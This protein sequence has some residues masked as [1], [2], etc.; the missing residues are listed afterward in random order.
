MDLDA[1]ENVC[2]FSNVRDICPSFRATLVDRSLRSGLPEVNAGAP[3]ASPGHQR[4]QPTLL[5]GDIRTQKVGRP[6]GVRSP[7]IRASSLL[8]KNL[9]DSCTLSECLLTSSE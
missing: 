2:A 6:V 8:Q 3:N 7:F 4:L 5:P 1:R 9:T